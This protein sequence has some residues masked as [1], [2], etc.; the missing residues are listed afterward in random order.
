ML[1]ISR[2][3]LGIQSYRM[4]TESIFRK[5]KWLSYPQMIQYES[6]RL[7]YNINN[8]ARPRALVNLFKFTMIDEGVRSVRIPA[9]IHIPKITKIMKLQLYRGT[10]YFSKLPYEIRTSTKASFKTRLKS[11]I[12]SHVGV[13][14]ADKPIT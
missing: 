3:I 9:L 7:I 8:L 6:I 12:S 13:Y 2:K 11:Y 14:K 5:L 4:S 10:F 1:K